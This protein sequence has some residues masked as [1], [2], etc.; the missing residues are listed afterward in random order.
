MANPPRTPSTLKAYV[1]A[2]R[3]FYKFV[4]ARQHTITNELHITINTELLDELKSC[5]TLLNGWRASLSTGIQP[6]KKVQR[7]QDFDERLTLEEYREIANNKDSKQAARNLLRLEN[8][9]ITGVTCDEFARYWDCII[10]RLLCR[11][12][13]RS[14]FILYHIVKRF[15]RKL[16]QQRAV[17]FPEAV[18]RIYMNYMLITYEE[19]KEALF[20]NIIT[21]ETEIT[22]VDDAD[23]EQLLIDGDVVNE[24]DISR[25]RKKTECSPREEK[26]LEDEEAMKI[27][28]EV[29]SD[30]DEYQHKEPR[31]EEDIKDD[32]DNNSDQSNRLIVEKLKNKRRLKPCPFCGKEYKVLTKHL[33][34]KDKLTNKRRRR[35]CPP[36]PCPEKCNPSPHPY[37]LPNQGLPLKSVQNRCALEE[38]A[39]I[40]EGAGGV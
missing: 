14:D 40:K 6:R 2:L 32:Y 21:A 19:V 25:T 11:S 3:L 38:C 17:L 26:S 1:A 31:E 13:Q 5:D 9:L 28:D 37:V 15:T 23:V 24:E 35:I 34:N 27:E 29:P 20:E 39:W 36:S 16:K 33:V 8:S 12:A 7:K 22:F 10:V 30:I 4:I 18:I